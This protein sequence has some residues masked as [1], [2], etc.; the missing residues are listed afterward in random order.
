MLK[1][2]LL[3]ENIISLLGLEALS[4]EEKT[5]MINTMSE[6]VQKRVT[7]RL[8]D[9]LSNEDQGKMSELENGD[10]A[11]LLAFITEKVP[12]LDEIVKEEVV[13][14]KEESMKLAKEIGW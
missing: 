1:L 14:L 5:E 7:L 8:M 6:L 9:I 10:P 13:R 11:A 4:P 3:N 12:N 2:D